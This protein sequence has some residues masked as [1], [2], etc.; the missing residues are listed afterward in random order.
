MFSLFGLI[1]GL[2]IAIYYPDILLNFTTITPLKIVLGTLAILLIFEGIR[3]LYGWSLVIIVSIFLMYAFVAPFMPGAFQGQKTPLKQLINYLYLDTTSLLDF[4]YLA[5]TMG[6][7]F[8]LFG[9]VLLSF[10]GAEIFSD[11]AMRLFGKYRGGPAKIAVAGSSAVGSIVGTPVANVM[12]TGNMTI[13]LMVKTGYTRAQA[14]AI[15]AVAA[16]GRTS[17]RRSWALSPL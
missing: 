4:M 5:A 10:G 14:G 13:P 9:Q 3:R 12:L 8:I 16:T 2:Y 7:A 11:L 15:E 17:C 1:V 6:L